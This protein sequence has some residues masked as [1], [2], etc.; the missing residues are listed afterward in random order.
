MGGL[1]IMD[2]ITACGILFIIIGSS[3]IYLSFTLIYPII[4]EVFH[5]ITNNLAGVG[6]TIL[7]ICILAIGLFLC[8]LGWLGSN[9]N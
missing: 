4:L 9:K 7:G 5:S 1:G 6:Y 2:K 8:L 3:L